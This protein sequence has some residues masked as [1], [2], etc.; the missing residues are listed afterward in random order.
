MSEK[1]VYAMAPE[2]CK[3]YIVAGKVYLTRPF[4]TSG[5]DSEVFEYYDEEFSEYSS[6]WAF[7]SWQSS[8][9]LNGGNWTRLE[10]TEEEAEAINNGSKVL[11]DAS[12][13]EGE[14]WVVA[15]PQDPLHIHPQSELDADEHTAGADELQYDPD[16]VAFDSVNA[17]SHY[18][19]GD[20]ECIDAIRAQMTPEQFVGYLRGNLV[21]YV[22]RYEHKGGV[23][24]LRKAEWYLRR[25]IDVVE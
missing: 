4:H 25:L 23:E 2:G 10:L 9:H 17:P 1:K 21:K 7:T 20:I 8:P 3:D 18:N 16:E 14:K 13:A 12:D 15:D 22:W 5:D 24:S 19:S 6:P 11:V